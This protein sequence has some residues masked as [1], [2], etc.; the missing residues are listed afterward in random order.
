MF[1]GKHISDNQVAAV[2]GGTEAVADSV[3]NTRNAVFEN[4]RDHKD[5]IGI[6]HFIQQPQ[7]IVFDGAGSSAAAHNGFHAGN[8]SGT[9]LDIQFVQIDEFNLCSGFLCTHQ[10]FFAHG[11]IGTI[12][13]S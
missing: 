1:L 3:D 4:R 9:M 2:H 6:Q 7:E 11:V 12:E 5:T 8:T 10:T 13:S